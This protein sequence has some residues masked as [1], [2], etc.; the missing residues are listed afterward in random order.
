MRKFSLALVAILI[1]VAVAVPYEYYR[2]RYRYSPPA[3]PCTN[4]VMGREMGG[5]MMNKGKKEEEDKKK[6]KEK[7][8]AEIACITKSVRTARCH[9]FQTR[10]ERPSS[11]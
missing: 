6:K 2:P 3:A 9:C 7:G 4:N 8:N 5:K 1:S 11:E 10:R